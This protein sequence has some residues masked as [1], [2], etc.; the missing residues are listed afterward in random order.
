MNSSSIA[1]INNYFSHQPV[2][3]AWL[4]GSVARNE[5]TP[6]SDVDILVDLD[7]GVGVFKLASMINDL[8]DMLDKAVDLVTSK[9]LLSWVK[10]SVDN[11][12]ILIYERKA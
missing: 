4:F 6:E 9:S 7:E 5:D 1:S 8:E 11:D 2:R 12:K 3:K 10:P